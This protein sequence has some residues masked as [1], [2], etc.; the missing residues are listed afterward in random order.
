MNAFISYSTK[1]Q[2]EVN[3]V[4]D[5]LEN[6]GVECWMAPRN[7]SAG[8]YFPEE[9]VRAI[10]DC[11]VFILIGSHDSDESRHVHNELRTAFDNEKKII[12]FILHDFTYSDEFNYYLS[13]IHRIDAF[14]NFEESLEKLRDVVK[15][16]FIKVYDKDDSHEKYEEL[17]LDDF[18]AE[19][20]GK[21]FDRKSL[22]SIM[23]TRRF[24]Y[25]RINILNNITMV[26]YTSAS[27]INT[28]YVTTDMYEKAVPF[29][30]SINYLLKNERDFTYSLV[31][32]NP[33]SKAAS[34]AEYN[35]K[36][37]N[38]KFN[39]SNISAFYSACK[40]IKRRLRNDE[41][42]FRQCHNEG[43]LNIKVTD[44]SLPYALMKVEYKEE[45]KTLN[46]IKVDLYSPFIASNSLRRTIIVSKK[47]QPDDY[48]FFDN[49]ITS[50]KENSIDFSELKLS[51]KKVSIHRNVNIKNAL[52]MNYRQYLTGK[53]VFK[54]N[55]RNYI[56]YIETGISDYRQFK[57]DTPHYHRT[58]GEHYYILE[59]AQKIIDI[60]NEKEI[61][62][63]EGDFVFI[64]AGTKHWTK[65][66]KGTKVFFSKA[67][68]GRDKIMIDESDVQAKLNFNMRKWKR[69]YETNCIIDEEDW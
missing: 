20:S 50:I 62:V 8:E 31:L 19:I 60:D 45:F 40:S 13:G 67:P 27:T 10:R 9:I 46:Y 7:I 18:F 66:K 23:G 6:Q 33:E 32:T 63:K 58:T 1:D 44:V 12:P 65:N 47:Y 56:S 35:S 28:N 49:Q 64:P 11:N 24:F 26:C 21:M 37:G 57:V 39:H 41:D 52:D 59:G 34:E 4:R 53:T 42:I 5:Y 22:E 51:N 30:E 14:N 2:D 48:Q 61:E 15:E 36:L 3:R 29:S 68:E 17:D 69:D 25:N 16:I 55:L 38:Q 54:N 43:R